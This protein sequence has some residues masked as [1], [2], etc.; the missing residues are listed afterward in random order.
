LGFLVSYWIVRRQSFNWIPFILSAGILGF[1]LLL[2]IPA[3][4]DR[5]EFLD[6]LER[7]AYDWRARFS[8]SFPQEKS[9][10]LSAIFLDEA[11]LKM[12]DEGDLGYTAQWPFARHVHGRLVRELAAQGTTAVA[13]DL[14]FAELRPSYDPN[15]LEDGAHLESDGFFAREI[16][17]AGNVVLSAV[18]GTPPH[19]RFAE[20]ALALGHIMAEPDSDGVLRR[21]K[22]FLD[23]EE[24][25]RM[26]QL[27]IVLAAQALDLRLDEAVLRDHRLILPGASGL[28]RSIPLDQNGYMWI[29]WSIPWND[30]VL[31]PTS[32][33]LVLTLD[34]LR[35]TGGV[36]AHRV[37]IDG[38]REAGMDS[39]TNDAPF[40]DKLAVVGSIVVGNN[41]RDQGTTPINRND[42]LVGKHWNVANSV[43][44]GRF[45]K[46]TP[47]WFDCLL[48]TVLG[49]ASAFWS[50]KWRPLAALAVIGGVG[51]AYL[52][53]VVWSYIQ[54]RLWLPVALP[55]I[56]SMLL[57][58]TGLVSYRLAFEQTEKRRIRA[59]FSRIVA[60][61]VV[62]ELLSARSL[63]LGGTRRK[64][65]IFFADVRGFTEMTD[66][67]QALAESAA[68]RAGV[69]D[70]LAEEFHN[71]QAAAT[72]ETINL[73]LGT[74]ADVVKRFRGTLDKYIG[75][76]VMAF[77]G[78]P[79][80]NEQHAVDCV[81]AAI[82]AQRAIHELNTRRAAGNLRQAREGASST[83]AGGES[84]A[85]LPILSLGTGINTG[86][87]I[88][89]LMGSDAHF[90]NYTIFGRE[91]NLASRLESVSGRSRII[92]SE[93]TFQEVR[94]HDPGLAGRCRKLDPIVVKGIRDTLSIYE[95]DWQCAPVVEP[96]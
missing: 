12:L 32:Y 73:Y 90:L 96:A 31:T 21:V 59:V 74:V 35:R 9:P 1:I 5:V 79:T 8:Q 37:G 91:V 67:A 89:G 61:E 45:V 18:P 47:F 17:K 53:V 95:V 42:F 34:A 68:T 27:G 7:R 88:V 11:T 3:I 82:E 10:R 71:V 56:G 26:W 87:A 55:L 75:D 69:S 4:E 6:H 38:A 2:R 93:A 77:W 60:P 57:S 14:L 62:N 83:P 33:G 76:C 48:L 39:W 36:E 52:M 28:E 22:P 44:L 85:P 29:D 86:M 54:F 30:P 40:K 65:T 66:E 15:A 25:G 84:P 81:R 49:G 80:A 64:I 20:P 50:W 23:L 41:M 43:I 70:Q 63:S 78:A 72:L 13:F 92:I 16:R 24:G 51:I 58:Y 19:P 94:R 46:R